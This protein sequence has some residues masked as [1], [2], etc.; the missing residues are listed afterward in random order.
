MQ[1]HALIDYLTDGLALLGTAGIILAYHL[2]LR[3]LARRRPSA[4]LSHVAKTARSAWVETVMADSNSGLLAIQ[5]LRNS[6]RAATF[7]AS[8]AVLLMVG[9]LNLAGNSPD[10]KSNWQMLNFAGATHPEIWMVKL[11][12]IL[13]LLFFA[14]FSMANAIR[15]F[16]HVGYMINVRGTAEVTYFSPAQV[17][18]ELNRGGQYFSWGLRAYYY[19]VPLVF[20]LFGP[21]YMVVAAALLVVFM[22]PE[23]DLTPKQLN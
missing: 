1:A 19:L 14:F 4:V 3:S 8:T 21:M 18:G 7:L 20:W 11:L 10:Q 12:S 17:A 16:T 5:T 23:I 13:L 6:T 9:V 22:L 2:Y 15:V